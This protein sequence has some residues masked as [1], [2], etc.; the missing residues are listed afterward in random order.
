VQ[1]RKGSKNH[2]WVERKEGWSTDNG[3]GDGK[4]RG[5]FP[6]KKTI[7]QEIGNQET[8]KK[9]GGSN[10]REK[11]KEA[12]QNDNKKKKTG[13]G[14]EQKEPLISSGSFQK[15]GGKEKSLRGKNSKGD[16]KERHYQPTPSRK[17]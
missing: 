2:R 10:K 14:N 6:A 11:G 13:T 15:K 8:K 9:K 7:P 3:W 5:A 17:E 16:N 12:C 4:L 1:E